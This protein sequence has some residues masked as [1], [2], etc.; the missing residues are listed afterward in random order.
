MGNFDWYPTIGGYPT[1]W[2]GHLLWVY[3]EIERLKPKVVV[4]LGVHWGHSFF[5]MAESA[6]DNELDTRLYGIDHWKGDEHAGKFTEEV[7]STA[8]GLKKQYPNSSL[9]KKTFSD[10][11]EDWDIP[12]D[13]LHIDGRHLYEDIKED[14][15]TWEPLTTEHATIILHD[16]QVTERDFGVKRFFEELLE[17][18]PE[19]KFEERK[20]SNGLGIIR[21]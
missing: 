16:T 11:S 2:Q 7:F 4:E 8:V 15:E 17:T 20:I 10:A 6:L 5:T 19:W 1:A 21:K 3:R 13:F 18:H 9:I 14:F 12:I